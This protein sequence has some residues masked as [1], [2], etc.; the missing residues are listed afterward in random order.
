MVPT[1]WI[2][3]RR[4]ADGELLGWIRP[5]GD[6]WVALSILGRPVTATVDWLDAEQALDELGL[7]FL[8]GIW[9]LQSD[10]GPVDVRI[11]DVAP[12][13]IAVQTDDFGAIDAPVER[14]DLPWPAPPAL[15]PR[16]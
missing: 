14:F 15:Q 16:D 11:V 4:Q 12:D 9:T 5:E 10:A 6:A 7:G 13:G 2:E 3:H 8:A 1:D